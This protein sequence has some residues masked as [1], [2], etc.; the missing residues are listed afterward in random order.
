MLVTGGS[1]YLGRWVVRL[2]PTYFRHPFDDP[3]VTWRPLDVRRQKAVQ[4]LV[5][6]ARPLDC[7][8]DSSQVRSL[9]DTSLPGVDDVLRR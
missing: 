6:E 7:T 9:L 5:A 8:L 3:G 1:G 4:S 2:A